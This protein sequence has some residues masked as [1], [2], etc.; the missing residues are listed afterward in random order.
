M[1]L[2]VPYNLPVA[3]TD[4]VY[5]EA[6]DFEEVSI[7]ELSGDI[8]D[9]EDQAHRHQI[10]LSSDAIRYFLSFSRQ[11]PDRHAYLT[12]VIDGA[13][14]SYPAEDG[15]VVLDLNR[16][17]AVIAGLTTSNTDT[18]AKTDYR[19][20]KTPV[21]AGSLAEA[22]LSG[23]VMLALGLI[24]DRPMLALADA[25]SDLDAVY[26]LKRGLPVIDASISE[27]LKDEA[28]RYTLEELAS[29]I[30]AM[31]SAID[32]TYT[33]ELPAVKVAIAKAISLVKKN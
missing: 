15:W 14:A 25:T 26:R 22:I 18:V 19:E 11:A 8:K 20:I 12:R 27:L 6:V 33:D 30:E 17:Q 13:K 2:N 5:L 4:E 31:T 7:D 28:E 29:I 1:E 21:G 10:L 32:G 24:K 16:M 3:K 23:N 9:I